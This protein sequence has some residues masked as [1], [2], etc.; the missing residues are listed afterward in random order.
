MANTTLDYRVN[1]TFMSKS[2]NRYSGVAISGAAGMSSPAPK[3]R[4]AATNRDFKYSDNGSKAA[5]SDVP[6][7]H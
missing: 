4:K 2:T 6:S 1:R 7:V 3:F 5:V